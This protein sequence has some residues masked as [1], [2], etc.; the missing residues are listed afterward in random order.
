MRLVFPFSIFV[1][2]LCVACGDDGP[3]PGAA[4]ALA[5]EACSHAH[6]AGTAV[7]A[8]SEAA[9]AQSVVVTDGQP[10]E[11]TIPASGVGY[12]TFDSAHEHFD[13]AIFV[14]DDAT[15][16]TPM[17]HLETETNVHMAPS[18]PNGFCPSEP[19][20]DHR[21]HMDHMGLYL[22]ELHADP[23]ADVWLMIVGTPSDHHHGSHD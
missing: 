2:L 21:A 13:Y 8:A 20:R 5:E 6:H 10:Y 1:S 22:V 12:L 16:H 7:T 3:E 4:D 15:L 17:L 11:V 23:G 14:G 19:M 18:A 9:D